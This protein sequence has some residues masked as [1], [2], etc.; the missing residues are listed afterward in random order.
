[1]CVLVLGLLQRQY[2]ASAIGLSIQQHVEFHDDDLYELLL[3]PCPPISSQ[4]PSVH[5]MWVQSTTKSTSLDR[6]CPLIPVDLTPGNYIIHTFNIALINLP[7][8]YSNKS[9]SEH[10]KQHLG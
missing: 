6:I 9:F 1:M 5:I 2:L 10:F 8:K 7:L 4:S 3:E